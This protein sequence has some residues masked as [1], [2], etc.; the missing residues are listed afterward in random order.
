MFLLV[1]QFWHMSGYAAY[2]W[3]AYFI[4]IGSLVVNGVIATWQLRRVFK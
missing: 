3:P 1:K 2:V 4:V